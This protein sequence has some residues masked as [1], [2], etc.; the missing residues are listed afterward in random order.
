MTID[1]KDAGSGG[2]GGAGVPTDPE[3]RR[4]AGPR[5]PGRGP[6]SAITGRILRRISWLI[7][8]AGAFV[9][10]RALP[11][12]SALDL[13]QSRVA[14]L[15]P[16]GP[17]VFGAAYCIAAVLFVPGSAMTLAAGAIF[18]LGVGMVTVSLAST[19]AA[20]VSF[21]IARYVARERVARIAQT[22]RTFGAIDRAIG[23]GGWR[24]IALLRLSPAVPFSIGNYL[25]GLTPVR[26][27]PYLIASWIAMLPGTLL[28]VYLGVAGRAA[29]GSGGGPAAGDPWQTVLLVAGL[30]ATVVVT[31]Y[32]TR[33]ARRALK[34]SALNTIVADA[35]A[36]GSTGSHRAVTA[37]LLVIAV[38]VAVLAA[39]AHVNR[40]RLGNLFG[41]P[42]VVMQEA[43][44]DAG[45]TA[46][47]DH[48]ALDALLRAHV[49]PEG[50]V[51]YDGL[52]SDTMALDAYIESLAKA[53]PE[54]L[55]RDE[56]LALLINAYNAFTLRLILD[57]M[58][59]DSIRDIPG[60][61]RWDARRWRLSGATV[62]LN[63][64][65][66][67]LIRPRF[68]EPRI[69]FA[70]VCAAVGCPP[71]RREAY[72]GARLEAQLADQTRIVHTS[73][74]WF[75]L[76][77]ARGEVGLT[78]LYDWYRGDFEQQ[79]G[80]VLAY[81]ARH[82]PD[83]AALIAGDRAPRVRFLDYDWRLNSTANRATAAGP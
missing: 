10:L 34:E 60:G 42:R 46:A 11:I 78:A 2:A 38:A 41:P 47:F 73:P 65:E 75:T 82:V 12:G 19:A 26:F 5:G 4:G 66:H 72:T 77:A 21:L 15:G 63:E 32:I 69:H 83:L 81:V 51:D 43:H 29:V 79:G 37:R 56:R 67:E 18:G 28:Y 31:V 22:H 80:S 8:V 49:D 35:P 30:A 44:A 50:F 64:I 61:Q 54:S 52:R 9:I 53:E 7:I 59:L 16:W 14:A 24:I 36:P 74:R 45:G 68:A 6:G 39:C 27:W 58:P 25:Y 33:L 20:G 3:R 62:S 70:L 48:G 40:A 76:D 13:L 23:E 57:H 1:L 17:L 71:L 55:G